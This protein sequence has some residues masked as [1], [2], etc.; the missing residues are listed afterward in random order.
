M[1]K[2]RRRK[3][4][5]CTPFIQ[6]CINN[7]NLQNV[8][9]CKFLVCFPALQHTLLQPEI[10][11]GGGQLQRFRELAE[12]VFLCVLIFE[13]DLEFHGHPP[14]TFFQLQNYLSAWSPILVDVWPL[15]EH[16]Q[17]GRFW[18]GIPC[19]AWSKFMNIGNK[20]YFGPKN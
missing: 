15:R 5:K 16:K 20:L 1:L 13:L 8:W 3:K 4:M 12:W 9:K 14:I 19:E 17:C 2:W 7:E 18:G 11:K 10:S 6:L